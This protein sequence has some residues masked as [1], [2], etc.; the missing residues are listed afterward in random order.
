MEVRPTD[1]EIREA[2]RKLNTTPRNIKNRVYGPLKW[3]WEKAMTTPRMMGG[4]RKNSPWGEFRYS[5]KG[6]PW[7]N[8]K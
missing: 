7:E 1:E 5:Q 6:R 3:S 2:A 8:E 4:R